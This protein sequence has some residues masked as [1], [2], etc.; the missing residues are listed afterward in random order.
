[1]AYGEMWQITLSH[2]GLNKSCLIKGSDKY[3]VEQK[4]I[5]QRRTWDAEE[6]TIKLE[7][8]LQHTLKVNDAID[9][10]SLLIKKEFVEK[11]PSKP[12]LLDIPSEPIKTSAIYQPTFTFLDQLSSKAKL[13]KTETFEQRYIADHEDWKNKALII[14]LKNKAIDK[15]NLFIIFWF[16]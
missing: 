13:R 4:A 5:A 10:D 7:S 12:N 14:E 3:V 11:K 15:I 1:M 16:L 9:W 2:E 8:V 6:S